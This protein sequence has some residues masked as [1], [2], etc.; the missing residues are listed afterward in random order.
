MK[1]TL[2]FFCLIFS[3]SISAQ[4]FSGEI[5]YKF[6]LIPKKADLDLDSLWTTRK[7][8]YA[9][10][11]ITDNFYKSTYLKDGKPTYSYTYDNISKRMYDDYVNQKY[12]TYRDS[13]KSN[14]EYYG[15]RINRDSLETIYGLECFF[16]EYDSEYGKM[17]SYYSD[18]IKVDYSSFEDHRVG[19]WYEKLKEVDGCIPIKTITEYDT[20]IVIQEAVSIDRLDLNASDFKLPV[21]KIKVASYSALDR[22]VEL[23]K[24]NRS[25]IMR[26]N[27][28]MKEGLKNIDLEEDYK[29]YLSFI[30]RKNGEIDYIKPL[31][32]DSLNLYELAEK[33]LLGSDLKFIPGEIDGRKVSSLAYFPIEFKK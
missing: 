5:K 4:K 13:R 6:T 9:N 7:G 22:R 24:P 19:N 12:I 21:N 2:A 3:F 29:S 26:Y 20:H 33:I 30:V 27:K 10:Y 23:I 18:E 15:S 31:E 32:K 1:I 17:K 11:L 14:N 28:L 16:V 8:Q 25:Q